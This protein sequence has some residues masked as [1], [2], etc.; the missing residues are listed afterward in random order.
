MFP[1]SLGQLD[2]KLI[3][4][5]IASI[6]C[7]FNR[8]I[9]QY[10]GSLL[11]DNVI[12]TNLY[13]HFAGIFSIIPLIIIKIRAKQVTN[14]NIEEINNDKG[15]EYIQTEINIK[16]IS[17]KWKFLIL[18][19]LIYFVDS[20]MFVLTFEVKTNVWVWFIVFS[21]F[22]YYLIFKI[23]LFK[24]HYISV[25]LIILIGFIIDP[26]IGNL[27]ND[28]SNGRNVLLLSLN[29]I[30]VILLSLYYVVA[31][32]TMEQKFCSLYQLNFFIC[33][34]IFIIYGI[35]LFF[36]YNYIGLYDYKEYYNNFNS[37]ELLVA[38]GVMATQFG[39]DMGVLN[40]DKYYSPCHIFIIFVFGQLAYYTDLSKKY[41]IIVIISLLLMLFLSLI[42]N[43]LIEI[44]FCGLS[45]NTRR[46]IMNR[47]NLENEENLLFMIKSDVNDINSQ[48]DDI[49]LELAENEIYN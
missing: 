5:L 17:G 37:T 32:Y 12:L 42:F 8:L 25:A 28:F 1:I 18:L 47:A 6:F 41:S 23:K 35:L 16:V 40:A 46:N 30:R 27:Q 49:L 15:I 44:N 7:F 36:D 22:L 21:S 26:L 19:T 43:E 4:I 33:L 45:Y 14:G 48:K 3:S 2:I 38:L 29:F 9:N 31:K 34:I 11:L 20:I 13:I 10:E 24:H 39:K